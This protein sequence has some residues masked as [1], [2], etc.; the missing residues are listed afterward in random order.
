MSKK[1]KSSTISY[2]LSHTISYTL[3]NEWEPEYKDTNWTKEKTNKNFEYFKYTSNIP[4]IVYGITTELIDKAKK[5]QETII[6]EKDKDKDKDKEY[7]FYKFYKLYD[8]VDNTNC[9]IIYSRLPIEKIILNDIVNHSK[10]ESRL[11]RFID[12]TKVVYKVLSC[13]KVNKDVSLVKE[14]N[15][16]KKKLKEENNILDEED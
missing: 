10:P 14:L 16:I 4:D 3:S 12:L 7:Y 1:Q 6:Q 9:E 13:Y 2:T 11:S 8:F 5:I 15:D